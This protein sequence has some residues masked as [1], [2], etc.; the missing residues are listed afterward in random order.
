MKNFLRSSPL[1]TFLIGIYVISF[2]YVRNI[3][4]VF[5]PSVIRSL[6]IAIVLSVIL[7]GIVYLF[8]RSVR[9]AGVFTTLLLAGLF[10]Y[11]V[12][13]DQLELLFY[14]GLWPFEHIHRFLIAS[15]FIIYLTLFILFFRSKGPHYKSTFLLNAIILFV[16]AINLVSGF[17]S[18]KAAVSEFTN[19]YFKTAVLE[20]K[21]VNV[22][23]GS[24]PDIYYIILDGYASESVLLKYYGPGNNGFYNFLRSKGFYIADSSRSN[25]PVTAESLASTL[26]LNYLDTLKNPGYYGLVQKNLVGETFKR[27]GYRVRNLE[28]GYSITNHLDASDETITLPSLNE[29]ENRLA[30]LTILKLDDLLGIRYYKRLSSQLDMLTDIHP[31]GDR[32]TFNFIH[33]VAPHPPYVLDSAGT[34]RVRTALSDLAW[35]PR[36]L[37]VEQMKFVSKKVAVFIDQVIKES[38]QPPI[39]IVQSD[40]GPW[41]TETGV[42]LYNARLSILNAFLVPDSIRQKLTPTATPV[43]TFRV[44]FSSLFKLPYDTLVY[45]PYSMSE[46]E[47]HPIFRT[48]R[49]N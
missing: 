44:L 30:D 12:F 6:V 13:Y 49:K 9:K 16:F 46:M 32:P 10:L 17:F 20:N 45:K 34:R 24:H 27:N 37:Y 23:T 26:N 38:K 39:I 47:K 22:T 14:K 3:D 2:V 25:Y 36:E 28:S 40:H 11:G 21:A 5:F 29:F 8:Y 15:Y 1:H 4:K 43:N 41:L 18:G 42:N 33:V 7:F 35:E 19:P 31:A 48:Y